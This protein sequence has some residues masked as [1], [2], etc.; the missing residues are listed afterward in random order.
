MQR[1]HFQFDRKRLTMR[2]SQRLRLSRALLNHPAA[3]AHPA[4]QVARQPP[5]WLSLGSLGYAESRHGTER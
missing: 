3:F 4:A 5:P 1:D 2:C